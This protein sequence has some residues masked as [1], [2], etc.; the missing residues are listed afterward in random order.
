MCKP[1][2]LFLKLLLL[3][4]TCKVIGASLIRRLM[5]RLPAQPSHF[6]DQRNRAVA[7]QSQSQI[8]IHVPFLRR[9]ILDRLG[10]ATFRFIERCFQ[11]IDSFLKVIGQG[12]QT[13]KLAT[14]VSRFR[15]FASSRSRNRLLVAQAGG[16]RPN[17]RRVR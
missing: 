16:S 4:V 3:D 11:D 14:Q 1:L 10:L 2:R 7:V 15:T 9:S 12:P 17:P 6:I 8:E 5:L 13:I